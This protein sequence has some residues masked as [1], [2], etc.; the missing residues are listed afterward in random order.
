MMHKMSLALLPTSLLLLAAYQAA[1]GEAPVAPIREIFVP[2]ESL[3]VLLQSGAERV[4]MTREQYE[5]LM[6]K[7]A[8]APEEHA[9][10]ESLLVSAN[11]AGEIRDGRAQLT[12][13]LSVE[14]FEQG[15]HALPLDL[16]GVGIRA[17]TLDGKAAAVGLSPEGKPVLFLEGKGVHEL[18]LELIAPLTTS[19]AQQTLQVELP[20][21]ATSKFNVTVPGNVDVRGGASVIQRVVDEAAAVTK[22][23]LLAPRG[24]M[25]LVLSLNNRQLLKEQS[26]LARSVLV[27]EITQAYERIHATISLAVLHG[28]VDQFRFTLPA[29]F[30]VTEI[31]SPALAKWEVTREAGPQPVSVLAVYLREPTMGTV[32]LSLSAV[33]NSR[34]PDGWAFP[35]IEPRN[36]VGQVAVVGLLVEEQ[37]NA[38]S[39]DARHLI[40]IDASVVRKALPE[41]VFRAEP[42]APRVRPVAAWYAPQGDYSLNA[43]FAKPPAKLDVI[44]NVVLKLDAKQQQVRAGFAL[45]PESEKLFAAEVRIPRDWKVTSVTGANNAPLSHD[46]F[47]DAPEGFSRLIV[48]F[49]AGVA[50]G[51]TENLFVEATRTPAKWLENWPKQTVDFPVISVVGATRDRGAIAV[52][53]ID[54]LL[55][56]PE[57][58]DRLTPLDE[59]EKAQFGLQ[60][61]STT[62]AYRYDLPPYSASFTVE[63]TVARMTARTYN[64]FRLAPDGL[65]A[66]YEIAYDVQQA[67]VQSLEFRLPKTTPVSV[68]IRGLDEVAVKEWTSVED[69]KSG[70]RLWKA[71]LSEARQGTVRL[72]VSFQQSL[73]ERLRAD[74]SLPLVHAQGVEYQSAFIAVEGNQE[75]DVKVDDKETGRRIDV[76][77]LADADYQVGPHLL[78]AYLLP[79][80]VGEIWV[81]IKQ[82]EEYGL[83]PILIERGK[84]ETLMSTSGTSVTGARFLLRSKAAYLEVTLPRGATLWSASVDGVPSSPQRQGERLLIG[85]PAAVPQPVANAD[86]FGS[87]PPQVKVGLRDVQIVYELPMGRV[88]GMGQIDA[89]APQLTLRSASGE[90]TPVPQADLEWELFLPTGHR[91]VRSSG[92]V[93]TRFDQDRAVPVKALL[94]TLYALTGGI[95]PSAVFLAAPASAYRRTFSKANSAGNMDVTT[96]GLMEAPRA[97]E[98]A[99]QAPAGMMGGMGGGGMGGYPGAGAAPM[100]GQPPMP[101]G[102]GGAAYG[103]M[104]GAMPG[105]GMPGMPGTPP[106]QAQFRDKAD[107]AKSESAPEA[108]PRAGR[109]PASKP[110]SN[111]V[112][113]KEDVTKFDAGG[114][115]S[116]A[117]ASSDRE[118]VELDF[119]QSALGR[120][121]ALGY[122]AP[123][124]T[125]AL[126]GVRSLMIDLDATGDRVRFDSLGSDPRL[127]ATIVRQSSLDCL[128][129][130]LALLVA[131]IG[132]VITGRTWRRKASFVVGVAVAA[133]VLP[134]LIGWTTRLELDS[135]FVPAFAA[136]CLLVP[137]YLLSAAVSAIFRVGRR[138]RWPWR[139]AAAATVAL[140]IT[141]V[142]YAPAQ[143]NPADNWNKLMQLLGDGGAVPLP[144]DA[145]V[146]PYDANDPRGPEK[147]AK[148]LV[149]YEKYAELWKLAFPDQ[150]LEGK[151]PPAQFALAGVSYK[152][153][154]NGD[155][156]ILVT[157]NIQI[158]CFV[159][160]AVTIPMA[161]SGGVLTQAT[162]DGQPARLS[163]VQSQP[164]PA[165]QPQA[166]QQ[167]P[168]QQVQ[169]PANKDE[170]S[171][172]VLQVSGKGRKQ[173]ALSLR[174]R[175]DR[176]GG[177]RI[178]RGSLPA[179]PSTEVNIT[180]PLAQTEVRLSEVH[181]RELYETTQANEVL[182]TALRPDGR[183]VLQW[184][185]KVAVG[186]VDERLTSQSLALFDIQEDGLRLT[187]QTSLE[188]PGN[189]RDTFSL[190]LPKDYLLEKVTGDNIRGWRV[191][192][193]G[194]A[195]RLDV[196]LL[197]AATDKETFTLHLARFTAI[198]QDAATPIETPAV[199][200]T[201]ATLQRGQLVIR[202]SPLLDVRTSALKGVTRDAI[203]DKTVESLASR[204][205]VES[206]LGVR[207]FE[208]YRFVAVP[209]QLQLSVASF[210]ANITAEVRSLLKLGEREAL[211]E[212]EVRLKVLDRPLH[213]LRIAL[214]KGF[215]LDEVV[216][217]GVFEWSQA[218]VDG[219]SQ[220]TVYFPEGQIGPLSLVIRG[221]MP[222]RSDAASLAVPKLA[223]LDVAQQ[224]GY[225]VVQAD[226]AYDVVPEGLRNCESVLLQRVF[227]WIKE[228]Q[229]PL[230]RAVLN[231]R[232]PDYEGSI[233]LAL[234]KPRVS[235]FSI[236]NVRVT[237]RE[238]QYSIYFEYTIRESGIREVSFVLPEAFRKARFTVPQLRQ[239]TIEDVPGTGL[240]RVR[241]ALQDEVLKQLIVLVEHDEALSKEAQTAPIPEIDNA[242]VEARYVVLE[243]E[244]RDEVVATH[245]NLSPLNSQQS[246]WKRLAGILKGNITQAF[247]VIEEK[248]EDKKEGK[249][250]D[251][252][253]PEFRFETK[254]R[255]QV[256]T[257]G[258]RIG[259]ARTT[260]TMDGNGVY[261]AQQEYRVDNKT[262]QYLDVEL[263][264][265]AQLWTVRVDGDVVKPAKAAKASDREH[266]LI[267][268]L[269]TAVGD[270]DYVVE[271]KYGGRISGLRPLRAIDF[272]LAR[273]VNVNVELSQVTLYL[274][275]THY[276]F[277]FGGSMTKMAEE[278]D[279]VAGVLSYQTKQVRS[280]TE[281]LTSGT[282]EYGR[283]R[284]ANALKQLGLSLNSYRNSFASES[285]LKL[286]QELTANGSAVS[287]AEREL[288]TNSLQSQAASETSNRDRFLSRYNTQQNELS[289]NQVTQLGDNFQVQAPPTKQP[290]V[291]QRFNEK[292]F[293][294]VK[295]ESG[296]A[297]AKGT[298]IAEGRSS[299]GERRRGSIVLGKELA[300]RDA[301]G[302]EAGGK[303]A[304]R[305]DVSGEVDSR[306]LGQVTAG[307]KEA[308]APVQE[309][310]QSKKGRVERYQERLDQQAGQSKL[311]VEL[312]ELEP[313]SGPAREQVAE[314]RMG[315]SGAGNKPAQPTDRL[316]VAAGENV[317]VYAVETP[318][319]G[320]TSL[321]IELPRRGTPYFFTTPRGD[322]TVTARCAAAPQ[323]DRLKQF[324]LIAAAC[325]V[326]AVICTVLSFLYRRTPRNLK[327]LLLLVAA[328]F[329][330]VT[331][332]FPILG[333]VCFVAGI[334]MIIVMVVEKVLAS[335]KRQVETTSEF[336]PAS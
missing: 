317:D 182:Q 31:K 200:V 113:A 46:R 110:R 281:T 94:G 84:L 44:S 309:A 241:L 326:G 95:R 282:N 154:L 264:R 305:P 153:T 43:R 57:K 223:V 202:R 175:L 155:Q 24:P 126:E 69:D 249:K 278:N 217:A 162:V 168:A 315:G 25:A 186:Q 150:P 274:P 124:Q 149:P 100:D 303:E 306:K 246:A 180:V 133:L 146:I 136:A 101:G 103:T 109:A 185:P 35:R 32:V 204:A 13:T 22:L 250:E 122:Q 125:W 173:L 286:Q 265:G 121:E 213:R 312:P 267:P 5:D 289:K 238:I 254:E 232:S 142:S 234:R 138:V 90:A 41:S 222:D 251:Q 318:L 212:A 39:L 145:V 329:S 231:Y 61:A 233:R 88:L 243:S 118:S 120:G 132:I 259:L 333:M 236:T 283:L 119:R 188:F 93:F 56:R 310:K 54:D 187:W 42:G 261:R 218:E 47:E 80:G 171:L 242:Q 106:P 67:R 308:E 334:V 269:K 302:K 92:T 336:R 104:P 275:D 290:E 9:P 81:Q 192:T 313:N 257:A 83:P 14:L 130:A 102:P 170:T 11:Y 178:A 205:A 256:E 252:K 247:V 297:D 191:Q 128:A 59:K 279:L 55:P 26:V 161:L 27:D 163:V 271:L 166:Q 30:E 253:S 159:D 141:C 183:F 160:A 288:A 245:R 221:S 207:S 143:D 189:Q 179:A 277:D 74:M 105:M 196:N 165:A 60:D 216:F 292:W 235:V 114:G 62:L 123:S 96:E 6:K 152:T 228:E 131:V 210:A 272:P 108:K 276:W 28:A 296:A 307:A 79:D 285:N 172:L 294:D 203:D 215:R 193:D 40:P 72:E 248:K 21:P 260:L 78:G 331:G 4:F 244:G 64:F 97:A 12:G 194:D 89:V 36:V 198:G 10:R 323:V 206:P 134:I 49:P 86:P 325:A 199:L 328:F 38:E 208:T 116:Q 65:S 321:D 324:G 184:R 48:R 1:A 177:W 266:V 73:D 15:L 71:L 224:E 107:P 225:L 151:Q 332:V 239:K 85:L 293:Y 70:D 263:P 139:T 304:A 190:T 77:E 164:A 3:D 237:M 174:M 299:G 270:L 255:K 167:A 169:A 18:R 129:G 211:Y 219:V 195:Q 82:R 148:V 111:A 268:L 37:L 330:F 335:N 220:V 19:A 68:S 8:R 314:G 197:K 320:L 2:F 45:L 240:V 214:P 273:T 291:E 201:G 300:A 322:I 7:A 17:A 99:D 16:S 76:G 157:G 280:L 258:A 98:L 91:V 230:C 34:A 311:R 319:T 301:D 29:G 147:A 127:R 144:K 298:R 295:P 87:R 262:E 53:G 227:S 75:F 115:R 181:D 117:G 52:T 226:P 58:L 63:R 50:A 158:D 66:H 137:Y 51:T 209:Y 135:L 112:K 23:E 287:Q 140:L 327:L 229:R 156:D 176:S 20:N 284:S 316:S 33:N